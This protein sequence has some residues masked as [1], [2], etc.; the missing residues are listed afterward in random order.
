MSKRRPTEF[1]YI[2]W[3]FNRW[4]GSETRARCLAVQAPELPSGIAGAAARGIYLDLLFYCAK[5]GSIPADIGG[6]SA[7]A[8]VSPEVLDLVW[9]TLRT[10]FKVS[11]RDSGRLVN[12]EIDTRRRAWKQK[13]KQNA[14]AGAKSAQKRGLITGNKT[15]DLGNDRST[16]V[17]RPF[18]QEIGKRK[19]EE[20]KRKEEVPQPTISPAELAA[21]LIDKY[22]A[23]VGVEAGV[24]WYLSELDHATDPLELHEKVLAGLQR[25]LDSDRW[26]DR[27]TGELQPKFIPGLPKFLGCPMRAGEMPSK[28]YLDE[29]PRW[30]PPQKKP[31]SP[32][33]EPLGYYEPD[34]MPEELRVKRN[35]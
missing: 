2:D 21:E 24:R 15:N 35:A 4:F 23:K 9:P 29:P 17:Q 11:K 10:K 31:T 5:D 27:E 18:N 8:G 3:D 14:S 33:A 1:H 12:D 28:M 34:W 22:P 6:L 19:E 26:R 13:R 7:L 25:Y 32:G 30:E 16:P 20:G